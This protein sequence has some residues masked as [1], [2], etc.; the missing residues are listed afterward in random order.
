MR[1]LI[2]SSVIISTILLIIFLSFIVIAYGQNETGQIVG[3]VTDPAGAV[4]VNAKVLINSSEIGAE[5][6]TL[7]N[8]Q[9]AYSVTNLTPGKYSITVEMPGFT[10]KKISVQLPVAT[11][12]TAN[13]KLSVR[14]EDEMMVV[15]G[16][17]PRVNTESQELADNFIEK[18]LRQLPNM[19]R[20]PYGTSALTGNILPN[21]SLIQSEF[22]VTKQNS[23]GGILPSS[24]ISSLGFTINGQPGSNNVLLDGVDNNNN[25]T[26]GVA[27]NVPLDAVQELRII[28]SSLPSEYGRTGSGVINI[29]TKYGTNQFQGT[30]YEFN[31]VA[32]LATRVIGSHDDLAN[33][34]RNQFGY[35]FGGPLIKDRLFFFSSGEFVLVRSSAE[36]DFLVPTPELI[37]ISSKATRNFFQQFQLLSPLDGIVTKAAFLASA[38]SNATSGPLRMLPSNFP[39]FGMAD[40]RVPADVGASSPQNSY[41]FLNRLDWNASSSMIFSLRYGIE[42]TNL[43][44][45]ALFSSPYQGFNAGSDI[46]NN[47]VMVSLTRIFSPQLVSETKVAFSRTN[48]EELLGA[49]PFVPR[50]QANTNLAIAFP[51]Y[52]PALQIFLPVQTINSNERNSEFTFPFGGPENFFQINQDVN[53]SFGANQVRFGGTYIHIQ[54][55]IMAGIFASS[56]QLLGRG[57]NAINNLILG[58][59]KKFVVAVDPQGHYPGETIQLPLQSPNF[60]RSNR[61]N[62]LSLYFTNNWRIAPT[63]TLN[64]GLRY[65][66]YGVQH[67]QQPQLDTNFYYGQ[68]ATFAEKVKNGRIEQAPASSIGGLYRKDL[69]NFAPRFGFAWDLFHNGNTSLRGGCGIGYLHIPVESTF[70]V[71]E[72]PPHFA[73]IKLSA[74]QIAN[75]SITENNLGQFAG[76]GRIALPKSNVVNIDENLRNGYVTFYSLSLQ[77]QLVTGTILSLD[78]AG[79]HGEDLYTQEE[80]NRSAHG[81]TINSQYN[82]INSISNNGSLLYNAITFGFQ[83]NNFAK[84]GLLLTARYTISHATYAFHKK[85]TDTIVKY[86]PDF[87][88]RYR[89]ILSSIWEIPFAI[90]SKGWKKQLLDGWQLSSI[91]TVIG[92]PNST[93]NGSGYIRQL[94]TLLAKKMRLNERW[95]L[96]IRGEVFNLLRSHSLI[97]DPAAEFQSILPLF[98]NG[99]RQIQLAAKLQF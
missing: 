82:E 67:N 43:F 16:Y 42:S 52:N 14:G 78:Y 40:I 94:D 22:A 62:E 38:G 71:I 13:I 76:T 93:I 64:F 57:V 55:N 5:R 33:F 85:T 96:Q 58:R 53:Y 18:Q 68:G 90:N 83:S 45:G 60:S 36:R 70:D 10:I 2:K 34:T 86:D 72:N 84:Q 97:F 99:R 50:L 54:D 81:Q 32:R 20:T 73:I 41:Q 4:V 75:L 74:A 39:L 66:Y 12:I 59:L 56:E 7:T 95:S 89:L 3:V 25:F 30:L 49:Q 6:Q 65:E 37:S 21:T 87:D 69:N 9:G 48:M 61:F 29:L 79:S 98:S 46:F 51:G 17:L 77:H 91:Y 19:D 23:G 44:A 31:R 92:T 88:R 63:F 80:I 28:T 15:D 24:N 11:R 8:D 26:G 47:N 35:S 27:L 1:N